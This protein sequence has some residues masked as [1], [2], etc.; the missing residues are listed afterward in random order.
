LQLGTQDGHSLL[1]EEP[2]FLLEAYPP[3]YATLEFKGTVGVTFFEAFVRTDM[4]AR[5][6]D[7]WIPHQMTYQLGAG[8]EL[9]NVKI[10]WSHTCYHPMMPFMVYHRYVLLAS[11]EGSVNDFYVRFSVGGT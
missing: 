1:Y 9:K 6:W 7:Q 5:N 2:E 4:K 8:I 3:L 10:G 11:S